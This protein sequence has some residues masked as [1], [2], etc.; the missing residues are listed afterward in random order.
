MCKIRCDWENAQVWCEE[1]AGD[2]GR[3]WYKLGIDP[4]ASL[5]GDTTT[6]WF[7]NDQDKMLEFI[8]EWSL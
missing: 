1:N 3:D 6:T 4:A 7:F 2:F 8:S 5:L